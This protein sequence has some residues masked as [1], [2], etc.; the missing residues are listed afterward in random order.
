MIKLTIDNENFRR[1]WLFFRIQNFF[2]A[3][4]TL[5]F[6]VMMIAACGGE[7]ENWNYN[8]G[9]IGVRYPEDDPHITQDAYIKFY[10]SAFDNAHLNEKCDDHKIYFADKAFEVS[11]VTITGINQTT[12]EQ[13]GVNAVLECKYFFGFYWNFGW[14]SYS[15]PLEFGENIFVFEASDSEGNW[16]T[17]EITII[18]SQIPTVSSNITSIS[19]DSVEFEISI[20]TGGAPTDVLFDW[21]ADPS[22]LTYST[23]PIQSLSGD[24]AGESI[25][26]TLDRLDFETQYFYRIRVK[27]LHGS[28]ETSIESFTTD[29][30]PWVVTGSARYISHIKVATLYG[31]V[32]PKGSDTYYWFEYGIDPTLNQ[33]KTTPKGLVNAP[34]GAVSIDSRTGLLDS[35]TTYYFRA[36]GERTNGDIY[37]GDILNFTTEP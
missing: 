9:W 2:F 14:H 8:N 16:G 4:I 18:R 34:S 6:L 30:E 28:S 22:F 13:F 25:I 3:I 20:Y 12:G 37:Y 33:H 5:L 10:G 19:Y 27:N 36:V 15:V 32:F 24:S 35:N 1:E 17:D 21:G 26:H 11:G 31:W 23:I 29:I 7:D